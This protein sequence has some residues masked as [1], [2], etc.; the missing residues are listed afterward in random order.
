[1]VIM[2]QEEKVLNTETGKDGL[3]VSMKNTALGGAKLHKFTLLVMSNLI[4]LF[5]F[6]VS[7]VMVTDL[8]KLLGKLWSFDQDREVWRK[9]NQYTKYV[10]KCSCMNTLS[11]KKVKVLIL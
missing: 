4:S 3:G 9:I 11:L 7:K 2:N 1:M 8:V 5:E 10:N 6:R